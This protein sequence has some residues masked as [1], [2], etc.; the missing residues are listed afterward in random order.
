MAMHEKAEAIALQEKCRNAGKLEIQSVERTEKTEHPPL[1]Y[2]LTTLQRDA[3]HILDFTAQQTLD[4]TQSLYER[5]L[6]TYPRTDSHYLTDDMGNMIPEL[7]KTVEDCFTHPVHSEMQ[8][9]RLLNSSKVT[10]HHAIIPTKELAFADLAALPSGEHAILQLIA[11]R[12]LCALADDYCYSETE[13]HVFCAGEEF[14][15]KSKEVLSAG[16]HSIRDYFYPPAKKDPQKAFSIF[17]AAT[18]PLTGSE[19][20]SGKTQAPKRYTEDTLLSAMQNAAKEDIPAEAER[21]GIGTPAPR[22]G[23][24]EKLIQKG[25]VERSGGTKGKS[26]IATAKGNAL[27]TIMPEQIQSASMT[28]DWEQRLLE[29]ER[30]EYSPSAFMGSIC[31]MIQDL[32]NT[33][34]IVEGAEIIMAER[35][36]IGACPCCGAEVVERQKGWFC[37]NRSCRFILWKDNAFFQKIGK[38]LSA[39][40]VEHLLLDGHVRLKDCKNKTTGKV[41]K[42]TL[43]MV[44]EADGRPVFNLSFENGGNRHDGP[45]E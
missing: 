43:H 8:F 32:I 13:T 12:F 1:L 19:V 15:C 44:T 37:A 14:S 28:A 7:R 6:V 27:I 22:A 40:I 42:A 34:K 45:N 23:I 18:L 33:S 26:L 24:I 3:N 31:T 5:K 36:I 29:I 11:V 9:S 39:P 30:G 38:R 21:Q 20:I 41:Y 25:Y 16:W 17:E 4:Y 2:D 35:K 10:D